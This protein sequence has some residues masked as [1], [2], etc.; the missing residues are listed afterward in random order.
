MA[1]P[2]LTV[3][4][5]RV[6]F[7]CKHK[8][9]KKGRFFIKGFVFRHRFRGISR[10]RSSPNTQ[11]FL[12]GFFAVIF[13][14]FVRRVY[15]FWSFACFGRHCLFVNHRLCFFRAGVFLEGMRARRQADLG[16][17]RLVWTVKMISKFDLSAE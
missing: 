2:Q 11:K 1:E 13:F 14:V 6:W 5:R 4:R 10:N 3:Y 7:L 17:S 12:F 16:G 8:P 15:V 9:E